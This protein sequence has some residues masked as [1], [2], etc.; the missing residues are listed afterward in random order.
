MH[1]RCHEI[2]DSELREVVYHSFVHPLIQD[3]QSLPEPASNRYG[4]L[5]WPTRAVDYSHISI[6]DPACRMYV[7]L[8]ILTD[9]LPPMSQEEL[10]AQAEVVFHARCEHA[11]HFALRRPL[12]S[13]H[14]D[15]Q[16]RLMALLDQND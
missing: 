5:L 14:E 8:G 6:S 3:E 7:Q 1:G 10:L 4:E 9:T 13:Y 11:G 16:K 15:T 12:G 2:S